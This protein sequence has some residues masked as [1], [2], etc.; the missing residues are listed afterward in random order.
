[1][2]AKNLIIFKCLFLLIFCPLLFSGNENKSNQVPCGGMLI[3]TFHT[4]LKTERLERVRFFIKD[5]EGVQ[6]MYPKGAAYVNDPNS[7]MCT[8]VVEDLKPGRYWLEF[9]V[10][11]ADGIFV[12]IPKREFMINQDQVTKIDQ[13][14]KMQSQ[15]SK[16]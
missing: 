11:N 15:V 12:E 8:V 2:L 3:V 10:P 14:I 6:Q 9:V 4:G 16:D 7:C 5:E 13:V 1:M